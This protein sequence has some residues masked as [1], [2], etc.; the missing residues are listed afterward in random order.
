M[1]IIVVGGGLAG[2]TCA[3]VLVRRGAE[4]VIF[5]AMGSGA[6]S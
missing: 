4:V 1:M 6:G 5:E 2:L 3:K